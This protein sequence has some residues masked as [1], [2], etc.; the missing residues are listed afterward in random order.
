MTWYPCSGAVETTL[1]LE[2][3]MPTYMRSTD[4]DVDAGKGKFQLITG[5][6]V[7][8]FNWKLKQKSCITVKLLIEDE[9]SSHALR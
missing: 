4:M 6:L 5:L 8:R 9:Q 7:V 2:A 1:E 3:A